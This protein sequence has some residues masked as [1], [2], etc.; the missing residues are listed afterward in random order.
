MRNLTIYLALLLFLFAS[1]IVAQETFEA[2][3]KT[4]A[5]KIENI[6]KDEKNAL[7]I[8]VDA[9]NRELESGAITEQQA[10]EKKMKLSEI[11]SKNIE[12]KVSSAQEELKDLVQ[13]KVDGKIESVDTTK[14]YGR[15]LSLSIGGRERKN[16]TIKKGEKRTTSQFVMASGVNNLV[17]DKSVANSDFRYWSS[18]FYELGITYNTRILKN[19]NLLHFK[20]GV[21]VMYNNLRATN[22]RAFVVNGNQTNLETSSI[23]ICDS[24]F[25]NV[26]VVAPLHLEFD[27]AGNKIKDGKSFFKTHQSVR[28]GIGG[29][30]GAR[31]KSKQ[32]LKYENDGRDVTERT[33]GNFNANDFIY[34]VSTYIGYKETSL[35]LKYDL[36][37]LFSNNPIKQNNISL[38]VRFDFN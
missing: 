18:H 13:Q 29:F 26:Y 36:N 11:R 21:S 14:T 33:R 6:I 16:D 23:N 1:K 4:I 12:T 31:V 7:K 22:N 15:F 28:L 8:E 19:N 34:G 24:R 3:A 35:Y 32:I 20:Y 37:P 10:D 27:F 9:V 2:K 30:A 25:K 5:L 17:T 38:G